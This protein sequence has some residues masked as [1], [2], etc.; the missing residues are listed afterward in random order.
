IHQRRADCST[1]STTTWRT[2]MTIAIEDIS[3]TGQLDRAA[4]AAVRGGV[5]YL[6]AP[7]PWEGF[8]PPFPSFPA[9]FPFAPYSPIAAYSPIVQPEPRLIDSQNPLLQ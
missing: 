3:M 5:A 1:F 9:G 4:S 8:L 7:A 6:P 2:D